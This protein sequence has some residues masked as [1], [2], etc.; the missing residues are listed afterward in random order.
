M[1]GEETFY[2]TVL[3]NSPLARNVVNDNL[4]VIL[5]P[6]PA[7]LNEKDY[8]NIRSRRALFARKMDGKISAKLMNMLDNDSNAEE[9]ETSQFVK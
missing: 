1:C 4:R 3:M 8:D 6:G 7:V 9:K 5:W 2:Q